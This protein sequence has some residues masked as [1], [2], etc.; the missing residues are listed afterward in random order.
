MSTVA[1][2]R[3]AVAAAL[4]T[5]GTVDGVAVNVRSHPTVPSPVPGDGWVVAGPVKPADFT[6]CWATLTAVL[7]LSQ[8]EARAEILYDELA[9]PMVNAVT[10]T[11]GL[12]T[13]DVT[14]D[15]SFSITTGTSATPLYALALTLTLEVTDA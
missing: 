3:A 15:P 7:V 6:A 14:L 4:N 1:Q 2:Q 9:V 10:Q 5:L 8:D 13:T 11:E 12:H